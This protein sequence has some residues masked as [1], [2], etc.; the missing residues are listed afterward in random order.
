MSTDKNA[1]TCVGKSVPRVDAAAKA[2]GKA[3]YT[4]DLSLP[5][6][7][8]TKIKGSTV[9]HGRIVK[10]DTSRARA[11]PGVLAVLTGED[12]PV[13]YS[14]NNY[15]PTEHPLAYK[16]VCYYGEG[17]A[18]VAALDEETAEEA[19]ALID[20]EIEPL[21]HFFDAR[22]AS[23]QDAVRIHDF[24][25]NN[26]NYSGGQEFGDPDGALR[27]AHV[28]LEESYYASYVN[29][30]FLEP[31]SVVADFDRGAD[32]LT[33]HT[34]IQL[35][36]YFHQTLSRSLE[37]PMNKIRVIV[38]PVGGAFG[39]KT[40]AT[41]ASIIACMLSRKL[42]RPVKMTYDRPEVFYQNKGRHPCHMKLK[43]GFDATGQIVAVDFDNLLDGGA[44][45]SWG[46]VTLWFTA[47]LLQLPYKM[48]NVRFRG[49]R[50]FTNKPTTGAQ[51]CLGG[52]QVRFCVESLLDDAAKKLGMDPYTIRHINAV[53]SGYQTK[54]AI[55]VRHSEFKRC[56]DSVVE[57]SGFH[58]KYGKLPFGRGIGLAAGHYST[59]GAYLLYKSY[60]P[61]S[62]ANIRVDTEAGVTL[63]VGATDIGQGAQTV[64]SQM[65]AEVL[66]VDY[67]NIHV[68]CQDTTL[69]PM[70][71]GTYDSRVTYGAGHAVKRAALDAKQ[72]LL[73]ATAVAL[74]VGKD[75]LDCRHGEIFSIYD[76]KKRI[77]FED[78][79]HGFQ[80]SVGP[81][82][83]TGSYTPPQ[84]TGNY[85]GKLIGPS[86]AFGFTAQIAEV[87]VDVE[88][89]K[90]A[91]LNYYE[92]GDCGK[93][94]NPMSVEGQVEGGISMGLG[95][96][97]YEEMQIGEDGS[98][99]NPNFHDYRIPSAMDMPELDLDI[100]ESY[101]P[102]APFG[103]KEVGEG[104]VGPV[105]PA[106]L[107]AICDAIGV[108]FTEVPVTPE[109]VLRA[110]GK[111]GAAKKD[112]DAA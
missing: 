51:R 14:V 25:E 81:L 9:A 12:T 42:G 99:L 69:A 108:R 16:K 60:R 38:P 2:R 31:Q 29:H 23:A 87:D 93:A 32:R 77:S 94:I 41:P 98:L 46:F 1:Y 3:Q 27:D 66:G 80:S 107:N 62:T 44:H 5:R 109:K 105:I 37:L 64:L 47:A 100:I 79:V 71:N 49:R 73:D 40:E 7:V 18:A 43:M 24:A 33:V 84:P 70:D 30:A 56:L 90:V 101:D 95:Q 17:V 55:G 102:S 76:P 34:C 50:V 52:V 89:G 74:R 39:G 11:Y 75:H 96:A 48:P 59:G 4:D 68:V 13:P 82:F 88:T 15:M 26:V 104:P 103:N 28:V 106:I 36:H 97:L 21:P 83:G 86:P 92:A 63:F 111:V 45:S 20:V 65:V 72:K 19:L 22:E 35:P 6:M 67:R 8:Y 110:L 61:H 112:V 85:E 57:R 91:I 53:D 54:T 10:V 58:D 78:A